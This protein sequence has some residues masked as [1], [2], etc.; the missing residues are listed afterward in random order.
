MDAMDGVAAVKEM[1]TH[2]L[3]LGVGVF[4]LVGGFLSS[5]DKEH[6]N[7]RG[8]L[9]ASLLL[10]GLSLVSGL[11]LLMRLV[12]ELQKNQPVDINDTVLRYSSCTQISCV[13]LASVLFMVYLW[14]NLWPSRSRHS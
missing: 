10:F 2:L 7:G 5:Q 1:T 9:L 13:G 14:I 4:A 11:V 3:Y 12:N 6:I 8:W